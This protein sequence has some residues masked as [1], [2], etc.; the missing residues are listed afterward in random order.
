MRHDEKREI[1]ISLRLHDRRGRDIRAALCEGLRI[2]VWTQDPRCFLTYH[3][4]DILQTD[5][6]DILRIPDFE[7]DALAPGVIV[8]RYTFFEHHS[9]TA[10]TVITD[11][12]WRG[13][14]PDG[15]PHRPLGPDHF[16][17][18][19]RITELLEDLDHKLSEKV[20]GL[21]NY[22]Q[23]NY[24]DEIKAEVER[25]TDAE[26]DLLDRIVDLVEKLKDEKERAQGVEI[27]LVKDL[28]ELI[29]SFESFRD[30]Y[31]ESKA[32]ES[33]SIGSTLESMQADT[34]SIR[35]DIQKIKNT[36]K[37]RLAEIKGDIDTLKDKVKKNTTAIS[38]NS[39]QISKAKTKVRE[40]QANLE[41]EVTRAKENEGILRTGISDN[42]ERL[43]EETQRAKLVEKDIVDSL[44]K[45]KQKVSD[46]ENTME[47]SLSSLRNELTERI[48][49]RIRE[50]V[51]AAPEALD[52]LEEIAARL[53]S[54]D[55]ALKALNSLL[56]EKVNEEDVYKKT[57]IDELLIDIRN[58]IMVETQRAK[59][60]E[61]ANADAIGVING[62]EN[63][64]G[65]IKHAVE[66]ANHYAD[67][68][69]HA[70]DDRIEPVGLS[71]IQGWFKR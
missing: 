13:G 31:N 36:V 40:L 37:E 34:I 68:A 7:M 27:K 35:R 23:R 14:H 51:G 55:D 50:I 29:E 70:L 12:K 33:A 66:D 32:E 16:K 25:A 24:P 43:N 38:K 60:A 22:I 62:D 26:K 21:Y 45:L 49:Y 58:L 47:V 5:Y 15:R 17:E 53:K 54:D 28:G 56:S 20:R 9:E 63:T 59:L 10:D 2:K 46:G 41:T 18:L 42:K 19:G 1:E 44:L 6:D 69:V 71:V 64:I 39:D 3:M 67:D 65:S 52:T 30:S 11:I 48:D 57:K 61:K 8:Y 4:R